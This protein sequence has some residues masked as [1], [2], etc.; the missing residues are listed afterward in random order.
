MAKDDTHIV[1]SGR[2][3]MIEF[4][5]LAN[6]EMPAKVFYDSLDQL[7]RD[8]LFSLFVHICNNGDFGISPGRFRQEARFPKDIDNGNGRLWAFKDTTRRSPTGGKG[9]FRIGCF[10]IDRRWILLDGFWKPPQ[11]MWPEAQITIFMDMVREVLKLE[12]QRNNK[13]TTGA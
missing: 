1:V 11:R 6:H 13:G 10:R 2:R 5:V 12:E 9:M 7:D 3:R 4:A 8:Q